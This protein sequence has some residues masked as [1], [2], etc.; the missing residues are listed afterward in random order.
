MLVIVIVEYYQ[1]YDSQNDQQKH[2]EIFWPEIVMI[3]LPLMCV[4]IHYLHKLLVIMNKFIR[5]HVFKNSKENQS[6]LVGE[7]YIVT[8][9]N[10]LI[11]HIHI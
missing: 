4:L 5:K 11:Y 10:L 2:N 9:H 6:G 8:L 3:S 1:L 7:L